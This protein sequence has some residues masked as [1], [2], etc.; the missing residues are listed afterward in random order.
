M[1]EPARDLTGYGPSPRSLERRGCCL[2]GAEAATLHTTR[3]LVEII[4]DVR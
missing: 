1:T 3:E 2:L 4:E